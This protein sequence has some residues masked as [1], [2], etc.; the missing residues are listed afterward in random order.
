MKDFIMSTLNKNKAEGTYVVK[1][2]GG[3]SKP[4]PAYTVNERGHLVSANT[5]EPISMKSIKSNSTAK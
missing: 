2:S 5:L 3:P 4:Q 1:K